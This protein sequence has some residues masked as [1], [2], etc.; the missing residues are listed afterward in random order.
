M[1]DNPLL[2][3]SEL[4]GYDKSYRCILDVC[5]GIFP[6]SPTEIYCQNFNVDFYLYKE[7]WLKQ[8]VVQEIFN[9][10]WRSKKLLICTNL[11]KNVVKMAFDPCT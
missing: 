2:L 3:I 1:Y 8:S 7:P 5:I 9:S 10:V 6:Q 11:G 4:G